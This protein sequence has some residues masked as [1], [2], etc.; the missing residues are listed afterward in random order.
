LVIFA[1][2]L[3]HFGFWLWWVAART[4]GWAAGFYPILLPTAVLSLLL[5]AVTGDGLV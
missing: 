5:G 4:L 1:T 3:G 2:A